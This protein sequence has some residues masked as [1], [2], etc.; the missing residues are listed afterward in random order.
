M[1]AIP[2][3][4]SSLKRCIRYKDLKANPEL[5]K[6]DY[7]TKLA[8]ESIQHTVSGADFLNNI[9][10]T[11]IRN[12]PALQFKDIKVDLAVRLVD[13]NLKSA[14][15][16]KPSDRNSIISTLLSIL[17]D[18]TPYHIYRFDIKNFY[19]SIDREELFYSIK[20]EGKCSPQTIFLLDKI[21]SSFD[22]HGI[23]GLPRGLGISS[24]L[25][26]IYL[27]HLDSTI[28]RRNDCFFYSRFVD[29]IIIIT[30]GD[31]TKKEI[32]EIID[33]TLPSGIELHKEGK[34]NFISLPKVKEEQK[35]KSKDKFDYL[36]Y[37]FTIHSTYHNERTTYRKIRNVAVD[38]SNEKVEKIKSRLASS[39]CSYLAS[40]QAKDDYLLLKDRIRS[41]TGNYSIN[42]PIT[43]IKI[44]TGIYFNYKHA[45][46]ASRES[47]KKL[48]SFFLKLLFSKKNK[49]SCRISKVIS[50]KERKKLAGY[51]FTS[52]FQNI[53]FHS[54]SYKK[55]NTIKRA[56]KK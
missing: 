26:E 32:E 33:N 27:S 55:L 45:N 49:L 20:T 36:G 5:I 15:K 23:E 38:I 9:K 51:T 21:F 40:K 54:F 10:I 4:L 1:R 31:S 17:H 37:Q 28:N 29:D 25:S 22:Y 16:V 2:Y 44:K 14:Y 18:G 52:G 7:R 30:S 56:W 19:E 48:D 6:S 35:K 13:K 50:L 11:H 39:F 43:G 24:T 42:D 12:K 41:L 53:R 3:S 46:I 8:R 47:L 34:R